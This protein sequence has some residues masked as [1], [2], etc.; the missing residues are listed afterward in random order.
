MWKA[1]EN[2][3]KKEKEEG[4]NDNETRDITQ[5]RKEE[6]DVKRKEDKV[7]RCFI[8]AILLDIYL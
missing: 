4:K 2:Q 3:R 6:G 5:V 8:L 1:K 7:G